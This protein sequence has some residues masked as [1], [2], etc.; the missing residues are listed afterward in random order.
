M[1]SGHQFVALMDMGGRGV[2][3]ARDEVRD[4]GTEV[5]R[6]GKG[7]EVSIGEAT[8]HLRQLRLGLYGGRGR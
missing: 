2:R 3:E 1:V 7:V 8:H 5:P 4:T 6:G